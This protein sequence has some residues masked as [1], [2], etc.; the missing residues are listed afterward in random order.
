MTWDRVALN[1]TIACFGGTALAAYSV[2][3]IPVQWIAQGGIV[4][5]AVAMIL[6]RDRL[7]RV[8]GAAPL[9]LLLAWA[10]LLNIIYYRHFAPL[11][12]ARATLPYPFYIAVRYINVLAFAAAFYLTYWL[13][14]RGYRDVLIKRVVVVGVIV[15]AA[16]FYIFFAQML[17]LPELPRTRMGTGGGE[18]VTGRFSS[19]N[20][21]YVRM[22]GTFREPSH[23]AE[24]LLVPLFISLTR[25]GVRGRIGAALLTTTMLL[26]VSLTGIVAAIAGWVGGIVALNPFRGTNIKRVA[27]GVA[28]VAVLFVAVQQLSVGFFESVSIYSVLNA[29]TLELVEG[30]VRASNRGYVYQFFAENPPPLFGYGLGNGNIYFSNISGAELVNS[31]LSLY[32]SMLYATGLPGFCLLILFLLTP[33]AR[34]RTSRVAS[35]DRTQSGVLMGYLAYLA[36]F[37]IAPE[38]LSVPFGIVAGLLAFRD[39]APNKSY[40]TLEPARVEVAAGA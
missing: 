32:V 15:G 30:G 20:I 38:E 7:L 25:P 3:P 16:A 33:I 13:Q 2:G 22:L 31:F 8:P 28:V 1:G 27:M 6:G 35:R 24:W 37:A 19:A 40:S 36:A 9:L 10:L 23:L 39:L 21:S 17:G 12:P 34:M 29:R 4:G 5:I 18:Q 14:A 26:T 11:Q